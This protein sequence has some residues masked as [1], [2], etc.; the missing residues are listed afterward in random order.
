MFLFSTAWLDIK[1]NVL[2]SALLCAETFELTEFDRVDWPRSRRT[3]NR[4]QFAKPIQKRLVRVW[5]VFAVGATCWVY[6]V[7]QNPGSQWVNKLLVF[8]K[9]TL[10]NPLKNP[11]L[12]CYCDF[13]SFSP[14][15]S[16]AWMGI[17]PNKYD[18]NPQADGEEG[19][20]T[21]GFEVAG[22][23]QELVKT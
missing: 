13:R 6:R 20:N 10:I 12:Q 19:R 4:E 21:G 11:L 8:V 3:G 5:K 17:M 2:P 18:H 16:F 1:E 15:V 9:G 7:C 22:S 23:L 14:L